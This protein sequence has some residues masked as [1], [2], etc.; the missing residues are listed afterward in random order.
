MQYSNSLRFPHS[1]IALTLLSLL[2]TSLFANILAAT[3]F[4]STQGSDSNDGSFNKPWLTLQQASINAFGGDT[5]TVLEGTYAERWTSTR[6]GL[7]ESRR[8]TVRAHGKV[9]V[10][11]FTLNHRFISVEGFDVT[12]HSATNR[13][14][15]FIEVLSGADYFRILN[16]TVRDGISLVRDDVV[17]TK[18]QDGTDAITSATGGFIAAGFRAGGYVVVFKAE[19]FTSLKA[20]DVVLLI[21][22]VSDTILTVRANTALVPEGPV[23]AYLDGSP[24]YG[25]MVNSGASFGIVR[26]NTFSNL[27][28]DAVYLGGESNIYEYNTIRRCNGWEATHFA[29]IGNVIRRNLI[30]D[31]PVKGYSN[32]SP[33]VF[34]TFGGAPTSNILIDSNFIQGFD[35]VLGILR[36]GTLFNMEGVTLKNNVFADLGWCT[37]R[38]PKVS[39]INNTFYRV[40]DRATL[41]VESSPHVLL[42]SG[43]EGQ[44]SGHSATI[45]NNIFVACGE[46]ARNSSQHG[47]YEIQGPVTNFIA[48]FNFVSGPAPQYEAKVGFPENRPGLNGGDPGFQNPADPLGPDGISFTEDDGLRLRADS[49]IKTLGEEGSE[50][51]AYREPTQAPTLNFAKVS[52]QQLSLSWPSNNPYVRLQY[53]ASIPMEWRLADAIAV[54]RD[55]RLEATISLTNAPGFFRLVSY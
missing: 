41:V 7:S 10:R 27:D 17:I 33:D 30:L 38:I 55:D 19:R 42:L 31:S 47:W 21:L 13:N 2:C 43:S 49:P 5:I 11:G 16:N 28:Y 23:K 8:I 46:Q 9:S 24:S 14:S 50:P 3:F 53:A 51:G 18:G 15:A 29:G 54:L 45:K 26:S 6:S 52:S 34:E 35:G 40:A 4:V 12:G 20:R 25:L 44:P 36:S 48:D 37:I 32:I 39:F 22:D 1:R